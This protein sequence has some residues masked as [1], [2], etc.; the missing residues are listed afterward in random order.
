MTTDFVA[1]TEEAVR[2]ARTIL[3]EVTAEAEAA[4]QAHNA[5]REALQ[6]AMSSHLTDRSD[7]TLTKRL[8]AAKKA[9]QEAARN[10][11]YALIAVTSA[12]ANL[13][14]AE[15]AYRA[16]QRRKVSDAIQED[17]NELIEIATEVDALVNALAKRMARGAALDRNICR[18][19]TAI[20]SEVHFTPVWR[21]MTRTRIEQIFHLLSSDQ[22]PKPSHGSLN[23]AL[24]TVLHLRSQQAYCPTVPDPDPKAVQTEEAA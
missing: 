9:E 4:A 8:E 5:A 11:D 10:R 22:T 15:Q 23:A 17:S 18:G 12:Q 24:S 2:K 21:S 3:G 16:A 20:G 13:E 19:A 7:T 1:Q 6:L 14:Q